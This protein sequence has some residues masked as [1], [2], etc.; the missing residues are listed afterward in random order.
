MWELNHKEGWV[1][2]NWYFWILVLEKMDSKEIKPVNSKGNPKP[3]MLIVRTEAKAKAPILRPFDV[4]S[5]FIGKDLDA[6]KD[7]RQE[8]KRVTEDEMVE[9]HHWLNGHEFEQ[10]WGDGEGLG[11]LVSCRS[12]GHK[13]SDTTEWL[14]NSSCALVIL[15]SMSK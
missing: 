13:E 5:W 8:E 11:N 9:W 12:W 7:W 15:G 6:G 10:T 2:K 4:K 3:W 1:P 14:N